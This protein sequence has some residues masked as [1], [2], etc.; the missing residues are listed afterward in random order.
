M[1]S[2]ILKL[3]CLP[4]T[5][6]Q[7]HVAYWI[8]LERPKSGRFNT[9]NTSTLIIETWYWQNISVHISNNVLQLVKQNM[10]ID[11]IIVPETRSNLAFCSITTK[12]WFNYIL[13]LFSGQAN[14]TENMCQIGG[15]RGRDR[16]VVVFTT[17]CS[18]STYHH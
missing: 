16:L 14:Q 10:F 13:D 1:K 15:V 18:I 5:L 8:L 11:I 7:Y 6:V 2:I 3:V 12:S 17:T 9:Y 4:S